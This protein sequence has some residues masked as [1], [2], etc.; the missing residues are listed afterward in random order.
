VA[1]ASLVAVDAAAADTTV[2][3]KQRRWRLWPASPH[4]GARQT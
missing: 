1:I 3:G 4:R 2:S